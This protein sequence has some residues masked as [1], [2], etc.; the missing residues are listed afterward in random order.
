[1]N[2]Y[3][4]PPPT[5][6]TSSPAHSSPATPSQPS[7]ASQTFPTG[8]ISVKKEEDDS[9]K[10]I[11]GIFN[12]TPLTPPPSAL[13]LDYSWNLVPTAGETSLP[14][15]ISGLCLAELPKIGEDY[16]SF[17]SKTSLDLEQV[18]ED[19]VL[20]SY[21]EVIN[22]FKDEF[23]SL[24]KKGNMDERNALI[25]LFFKVENSCMKS[26]SLLINSS[27]TPQIELIF[28]FLKM[29]MDLLNVCYSLLDL[30]DQKALMSC[31]VYRDVDLPAYVKLSNEWY[32]ENLSNST[33]SSRESLNLYAFIPERPHYSAAAL[34]IG[35]HV[36]FLHMPIKP[37]TLLEQS[38]FFEANMRNIL[39]YLKAKVAPSTLAEFK[40][41]TDKLQKM[42]PGD[43]KVT[44]HLDDCTV[45]YHIPCRQYSAQ[46]TLVP[47]KDSCVLTFFGANHFN[48]WA[49]LAR[50]LPTLP[51]VE[52]SM[53]SFND[54]VKVREDR[55]RTVA[56]TLKMPRQDQLNNFIKLLKKLIHEMPKIPISEKSFINDL[57]EWFPKAEDQDEEFFQKNLNLISYFLAQDIPRS[58]RLKIAMNALIG[59]AETSDSVTNLFGQEVSALKP[60][61]LIPQFKKLQAEIPEG[62][63]KTCVRIL[64]Q[65]IQ[66]EKDSCDW[67][68]EYL[69]TIAKGKHFFETSSNIISKE[70]ILS[71][72]EELKNS[73]QLVEAVKFAIRC[74]NKAWIELV[75]KEVN[76]SQTLLKISPLLRG[77][78]RNL[79]QAC[80]L[81]LSYSETLAIRH[82]NFILR[83]TNELDQQITKLENFDGNQTLEL[84][85][86]AAYCLMSLTNFGIRTK[87]DYPKITSYL[88]VSKYNFIPEN[89]YKTTKKPAKAAVC[90]LIMGLESKE[91]DI[92]SKA[93]EMVELLCIDFK[94]QKDPIR[95]AALKSYILAA[96][97]I[98]QSENL[99]VR[100]E[101]S[102]V[103]AEFLGSGNLILQKDS[104]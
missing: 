45:S 32:E 98:C 1:M 34:A 69:K 12:Q 20:A 36:D 84:V 44:T 65:A 89:I 43:T 64:L 46:V 90:H 47:S 27:E 54:T 81:E 92:R 37:I 9:D 53:M 42:A 71:A 61:K 51:C 67:E 101:M 77:Q 102:P 30:S 62:L 58:L 38:K 57:G 15:L 4:T 28:E 95:R 103:I 60:I 22:V 17:I 29:R 24:Y 96:V 55:S 5:A 76:D 6:T 10:K 35:S 83:E 23:C 86:A 104:K 50:L 7:V 25:D 85:E 97:S 88:G 100:G 91:E 14:S 56:F 26:S 99:T 74:E 40:F 11:T 87:K 49:D 82:D 21:C 8:A 13:S 72:F 73:G 18:F 39:S 33:K 63:Q 48:R 3:E 2:N 75:L 31:A 78:D 79:L 68:V 41:F 52:L 66:T 19:F 80:Q 93:L 59:M 94:S 70:G 16:T